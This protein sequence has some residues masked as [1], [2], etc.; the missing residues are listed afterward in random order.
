MA[1]A[2]KLT[3]NQKVILIIDNFI[4]DNFSGVEELLKLGWKIIIITRKDI[5]KG[6][7]FCLNIEAIQE[8]SDMYS[9]FESYLRRTIELYEY[10]MID[11]IIE[12]VQGHTLVLELIA[13]QIANSFLSI[14]EAEKLMEKNGFS[15][16]AP[17][18]VPYTRDFIAYTDTI[19]NIIDT[20]FISSQITEYKNLF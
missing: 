17:E 15:E 10:P 18:K 6:E 7:Y 14:S 12:K 16:I 4:G 11:C 2:R 8:K 13:K 5:L 9:M 19:K 1:I 3:H 20:L